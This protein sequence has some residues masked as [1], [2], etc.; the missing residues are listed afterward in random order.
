MFL[1]NCLSHYRDYAVH[2][3]LKDFN[4]VT[5]AEGVTLLGARG[6]FG[7]YLDDGMDSVRKKFLQRRALLQ[8]PIFFA[9][10][11]GPLEQTDTYNCG[12]L[13]A[14]FIKDFVSTQWKRSYECTELP[15]Q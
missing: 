5:T 7:Y 3:V 2:D 1:L 12:L 6:P 11:H 9:E 13:A 8:L 15:D 14:L 10:N 4:P